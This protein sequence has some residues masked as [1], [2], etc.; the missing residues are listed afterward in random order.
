EEGVELFE[1][2]Q[3]I[4]ELVISDV[5]MP[6]LN[7]QEVMLKIRS[8]KPKMPILLIT[9]YQDPL[10]DESVLIDKTQIMLKPFDYVTLS[11]KVK[12]L[13]N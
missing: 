11:H 5:A 8:I 12:A 13:L 2:K 9:G 6:K 1:Q 4:I 10:V 3:D 7:G